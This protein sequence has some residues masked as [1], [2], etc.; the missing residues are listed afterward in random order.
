MVHRA[1]LIR[2]LDAF[3]KVTVMIDRY[4][5]DSGYIE[6]AGAIACAAFLAFLQSALN[7]GSDQAAETDTLLKYILL[8]LGCFL[9]ASL[10]VWRFLFDDSSRFSLFADSSRIFSSAVVALV[11]AISSSLIIDVPYILNNWG[12]IEISEGHYRRAIESS[13]FI[14]L[15]NISIALVTM[16]FIYAIG[17]LLRLIL[18]QTMKAVLKKTDGV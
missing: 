3:S 13:I 18:K 1:A 16:L 10:L 6:L 17:F 15:L 9:C 12:Y 8:N 7:R 11:G 4:L 14:L 5:K 2:A